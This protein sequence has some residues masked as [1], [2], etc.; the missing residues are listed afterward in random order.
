MTV[1]DLPGV[2]YSIGGKLEENGVKFVKDIRSMTKDRLITILGPKTGEK[3]W[4][5][6]RGID[7]AEV[8]EQVER[9]SVS[10]EVNWGIRFISQLEAEEFVQNLCGELH[11]RLQEQRVKGRQLTMKIMRRAADAPLD[12]PKHLG[13]GKCDTFNKSIV[14]GVATNAP[15]VMGREAISIL[16]GYGFSPGELRGLGVQMTKLEPLKQ[17]NNIFD[18][19]QKRI[20]FKPSSTTISETKHNEDPIVDD[21]SPRKPRTPQIHPAAAI[22]TANAAENS[23]KKPLNITGTQFILPSQVDPAVLAELPPDIRS[24]LMAQG[25]K[26]PSISRISSPSRSRSQSPARQDS[27]ILPSQLDPEVFNALPE[28]IKSEVLAQYAA[29]NNSARPR[30]RGDQSLLPQ[31]P[32]KNRTINS[33]KIKPPTPSKKRGLMARG[34]GRPPKI[35]DSHSTLTQ[36]N[37]IA[38]LNK[39]GGTNGGGQK[40]EDLEEISPEI[41][42]ALPEDIR[43]EVLAEHRR[44]RLARRSNL[45]VS[46]NQMRKQRPV[47]EENGARAPPEKRKIKLPPKPKRPTFTV[48]KLWEVGDLREAVGEWYSEFRNDGPHP[49]DVGALAR[50][51]RKVVLDERNMAKVVGVVKWLDWVVSQG[52]E[53]GINDVA[54]AEWENSVNTI[55]ETVQSAVSERGLGKIDL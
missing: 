48:E 32:R 43:L 22:A 5:Y 14:L 36:S 1:Q 11:R 24:R 52:E 10:A 17:S 44:D 40:E 28:E 30:E 23:N 37:F 12:P 45:N 31:S 9:K 8:G 39:T 27:A 3:I 15:D 29:A 2:A 4:D 51:L 33:L 47:R 16:R 19:S 21:E 20:S 53:S 7:R 6:S 38:R 49:D 26:S 55:K 54:K 34:R 41:L 35:L 25:K 18:G 46:A 50:Y 13:H 42:A